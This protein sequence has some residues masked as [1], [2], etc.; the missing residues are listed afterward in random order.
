MI[1]VDDGLWRGLITSEPGVFDQMYLSKLKPI[2]ILKKKKCVHHIRH[3]FSP[4]LQIQTILHR[5]RYSNFRIRILLKSDQISKNF[6][7]FFVIFIPFKMDTRFLLV[8]N[9]F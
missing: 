9:L 1:F 6:R 2:K 5:I 3:I 7:S 4:V 8:D